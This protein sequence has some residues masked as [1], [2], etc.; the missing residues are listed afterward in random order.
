MKK[1]I[2]ALS[3]ALAF[4][5][6][7]GLL[8]IGNLSTIEESIAES[9]SSYPDLINKNIQ[10]EVHINQSS[11]GCVVSSAAMLVRRAAIINGLSKDIWQTVTESYVVKID[12]NK[13]LDWD[14]T[15]P[16][17]KNNTTYCKIRL[18]LGSASKIDTLSEAKALLDSNPEGILFYVYRHTGTYKSVWDSNKKKYVDKEICYMHGVLLTH[19]VGDTI[20]C[21][22]PAK[23]DTGLIKLTESILGTNSKYTGINNP[24][25]A[26]ILSRANQY[27]YAKSGI[28]YH[29][30][31]IDP[32]T[33]SCT[34][35]SCLKHVK[36][37][38]AENT[39]IC[40]GCN[41]DYYSQSN[42]STAV[43]GVATPAS[44]N[45]F[46][47]YT[48]PYMKS[49]RVRVKGFL[50]IFNEDLSVSKATVVSEITNHL[51][52]KWYQLKVEEISNPV[53]VS[54]DTVIV[55]WK[56]KI[57]ITGVTAPKDQAVEGSGAK[58]V[59]KGTVA[60]QNAKISEVTA[61]VYDVQ[62]IML[63]L[64]SL[65]F[66]KVSAEQA[67]FLA[68]SKAKYYAH[69]SNVNAASFNLNQ[70]DSKLQ[71]RNLPGGHN[72]LYIVTAT[73][74]NGV[75]ACSPHM[76]YLRTSST[77][78]TTYSVMLNTNGSVT[79]QTVNQGSV[80]TLPTKTRAGHTFLGWA[81]S[82]E[83]ETAKYAPN[84]SFTP[85]RNITLYAIFR[86][87]D[88]PTTPVLTA[89]S[90][91][92]AEGATQM[93]SWNA[94]VGAT[95]YTA[96]VYDDGGTK[97]YEQSSAGTTVVIP[98]ESVGVYTVKVEAFNGSLAGGSGESEQSAT[99]R[100]HGP[101]TVTFL[102]HDGSVYS[103]QQVPYGGTA[104]TPTSPSRA[105]YSF[106]RWEG[107]MTQVFADTTLTAVY[108]PIRYKVTFCDENGNEINTQYVTYNGDTPGS[109]VEP[110]APV[111]ANY[112]FVGWNTGAWEHVMESGI[113]VYP[114]YVWANEDVPLSIDIT[115]V[116]PAGDGYWVYY[117]VT[118]HMSSAQLGR[119]VIAGKTTLGKFIT[120]TESG[121][122][123]LTGG[124]GTS[125]QG[126]AYVPVASSDMQTLATVEA[127]V[128]DSY[129]TKNPI[130]EPDAYII[131]SV[132]GEYSA[133]M[134][135]DELAAFTAP[136]TS[137]EQS[138]QYSTRTKSTYTTTASPY[139]DW[140]VESS[141][142][143]EGAWGNWSE[144]QDAEVTATDRIEVETRQVEVSAAHTEYRYGRWYA[145]S[146]VGSDSRTTYKPAVSPALAH[147][148]DNYKNAAT[149]FSRNYSSWSTTRYSAASGY[150][151]TT[152][153]DNDQTYY[154]NADFKTTYSNN[155]QTYYKVESGYYYWHK[156]Y[157]GSESNQNKYLWEEKRTVPAEYKTQYRY[158]VKADD[159][160]TYTYYHWSDW[161]EYSFTPATATADREV[162]TRPVYRV[163]LSNA[164]HGSTYA[165][166]GEVGP[167]AAGKQAILNVY[168]VEAA[169]DYS[170][171]YIEQVTLG[172]NGAYSFSFDTLETPSV[173][174]GDYTVSLT[175][176]GGTESLYIG[177]IPAPKPQYTV[178]FVDEVTGQSLG[179]QT[180]EEG[181]AA[182]A[183]VVP[184]HEGYYFLGWEYGLD[185]IRED[186]IILA[187]YVKRGYTVVFVDDVQMSV[188]MTNDIPY[189]TAVIAPEVTA[190]EGYIFIGWEAPAGMSL[191]SV[192]GHMIITA[193]YE[194]IT[195]QV[196]FL[197]ADGLEIARQTV[198]YGEY[199]EDPFTYEGDLFFFDD[200]DDED[201]TTNL[202]SLRGGA[203]IMNLGSLRTLNDG[204]ETSGNNASITEGDLNIPDSMY[205]VGWSEGAE[206]PVTQT[207][208]LMPILSY[209]E[210][211]DEVEA[212]LDGG[213]YVGEQTTT[214]ET[215]GSIA[216]LVVLY[217]IN[218]V[219]GVEGEWSEYDLENAPD[220]AISETCV[221]EIEA[222]AENKNSYT[223]SY[224][225]V[226]VS[227]A[228]QLVAPA[229]ITA[230]QNDVE[231]VIVNWANVS[232]A[233][234]YMVKRTSDCDETAEFDV[235][236]VT[237]FT[238]YGVD[239]LRTYTYQVFA[240]SMI[241]RSG[242]SLMLE[243]NGSTEAEVFFY[244]DNTLVSTVAITA[245]ATVYEGSATQ[246]SATV[247]PVD[248]YDSSVSWICTD[249]TGEGY[250]TSDGLFYGITPGTVN[251]TA[252]ALDGSNQ[253]DTVT[254]TVQEIVMGENHT[255]ITV[256][257][258]QV[259][260]G[261][262]ANV[263]VSISEN[264]LADK[265]QFALL[266]DS[267]KLTLTAFDAGEAMQGLAPTISN[268][269]EGVVLF[270]WESLTSLTA[271]GS[272]LDLT[273]AVKADASGTALVEIP[274]DGSE[275]DFIFAHGN[276]A[277]TITVASVNGMLDIASLLLGDVDESGGVNVIDANMIRR[278]AA[279]LMDLSNTQLLAADVNGD[280]KVNVIDANLIRRYV[281]HLISVFPADSN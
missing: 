116:T 21:L 59:V 27:W 207:L 278:Y 174:T 66:N 277:A 256:S 163:K 215:D 189:E 140:E 34:D 80:I 254:I 206:D 221:L 246:L 213:I 244:G 242:S 272:M 252:K 137:T 93:I 186:M 49:G 240:Y 102:N 138:M 154:Q 219:G 79:M 218:T 250:V 144:W 196:S 255:T 90:Y 105:G 119:V 268:P 180:V 175:I 84:I 257:S 182:I 261:G 23:N 97:V 146:A 162:Q 178:Q 205:F 107:S 57:T 40:A 143:Q 118:N 113:K 226:I 63:D 199:A 48:K 217:R 176:A 266:Y 228:D 2:R 58:T 126:N 273:F 183:P 200:D 275:Y 166:S 245:P 78:K 74:T 195:N 247:A 17:K 179:E 171:Q 43:N 3:L 279:R 18:V 125:Y 276:D 6:V 129:I 36:H 238:D 26:Q 15:I 122:F 192:T 124:D 85:S 159:I 29:Q 198:G 225:Y 12:G 251:V 62:D 53:Y 258:A 262:T 241:E 65:Q 64:V 177:T 263:S 72:Y 5:F 133:W 181:S 114:V 128:V 73:D 75:N 50:G 222:S 267:A 121:A 83:A 224:E 209:I 16:V 202:M 19:Y 203:T 260:A 31:T 170:N 112:T 69:S 61:A 135:A 188:S 201:L 259:R 220:I 249:G 184:E 39:G 167:S 264:S 243:G 237:S 173:H 211:V 234:G 103:T 197:A 139:L 47:V 54:A 208:T 232:G 169:S 108:T 46:Y 191:D 28:V 88:P 271:E 194:Q 149:L 229:N 134:T 30:H 164:T 117:T 109:A 253:F 148:K 153:H 95:K 33:G 115:S 239:A 147:A 20:Y 101:S 32:Y 104:D 55:Q 212:T 214:L 223:A 1:T 131:G 42:I 281:A 136:Y 185:N 94:V 270:V 190:P 187:R 7:F 38:W 248:A 235:G 11:Q 4:L 106:S 56:S 100:V 25:Q 142:T 24:S 141:T 82:E 152:K 51:G 81:E 233:N 76:F 280:G 10:K 132:N 35:P 157:L 110:E 9:A 165:F 127:Y 145:A 60:V 37:V 172:A 236:T 41:L 193:K 99:V 45:S 161:S 151:R 44:G 156:Y 98:F 71:F 231:S 160:T 70:Y 210:D 120:Q 111:K 91:D 8:P 52:N 269:S 227:A 68:K 123:Y 87:V 92:I 130:A 14:I 168:K 230:E 155:C 22:D 86:E 265:I 150:F 67:Y 77:A 274:T 204:N 13:S 216:G 96:S 158:R 89:Q